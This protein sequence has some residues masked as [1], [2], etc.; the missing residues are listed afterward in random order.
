MLLLAPTISYNLLWKYI[1]Y[2]QVDLDLSTVQA[3][4]ED[5][6]VV[7]TNLTEFAMKKA[8]PDSQLKQRSTRNWPSLPLK[9]LYRWYPLKS[10]K[11]SSNKALSHQQAKWKH[12]RKT[13]ISNSPRKSRS[14]RRK[15]R[16]QAPMEKSKPDRL[17]PTQVLK[18]PQPDFNHWRSPDRSQPRVKRRHQHDPKWIAK[19]RR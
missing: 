1:S 14:R 8:P 9:G 7:Q 3:S 19:Q 16:F 2:S 17:P 4:V 5:Q 15:P 6:I 10:S 11:I 13:Q 12:W 18:R